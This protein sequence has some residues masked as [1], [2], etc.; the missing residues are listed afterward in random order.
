MV[1][2][3]LEIDKKDPNVSDFWIDSLFDRFDEDKSG[4]IDDDEWEHLL[5]A[6]PTHSMD[7]AA[8]IQAELA[9]IQAQLA[10]AELTALE[11]RMNRVRLAP[12]VTDGLEVARQASPLVPKSASKPKPPEKKPAAT[13]R[14]STPLLGWDQ[15]NPESVQDDAAQVQLEKWALEKQLAEIEAAEA[16]EELNELRLSSTIVAEDPLEEAARIVPTAT[17]HVAAA[18]PE[19]AVETRRLPPA[20]DASGSVMLAQRPMATQLGSIPAPNDTTDFQT[21]PVSPAPPKDVADEPAVYRAFLQLAA[22]EHTDFGAADWKF[23]LA[24]ESATTIGREAKSSSRNDSDCT[25][26]GTADNKR[27]SRQH[28]KVQ[29]DEASGD[30]AVSGIGKNTIKVNGE[31]TSDQPVVIHDGDS[32]S[33]GSIELSVK[34]ESSGD[35][36]DGSV[37][38]E[39]KC[40]NRQQVRVMVRIQL[41]L[42]HGAPPK[43]SDTWID[44][45]FD[46][47]DLDKSDTI[48][49]AEWDNMVA[50]L[51]THEPTTQLQSELAAIERQLSIPDDAR[52]AGD[53]VEAQLIKTDPGLAKAVGGSEVLEHAI[54][55]A[56]TTALNK[57]KKDLDI[58]SELEAKKAALAKARASIAAFDNAAP[59][60]ET[61]AASDPAPEQNEVPEDWVELDDSELQRARS[62]EAAEEISA[63]GSQTP[64]QPQETTVAIDFVLPGSLGLN[65]TP[66]G[67]GNGVMV[68][69]VQPAGQAA[70]HKEL[71]P[72]L[73]VTEVGGV[74][75]HGKSYDG[76]IESI[77]SHSARPLRIAFSEQPPSAPA[78]QQLPME[79]RLQAQQQLPQELDPDAAIV[80]EQDRLESDIAALEAQ[81]AQVAAAPV[82]IEA[83]TDV[84]AR[85]DVGLSAL[86]LVLQRH[87]SVVAEGEALARHPS[88]ADKIEHAALGEPAA[89]STDVDVEAE[90]ARV[91][92][93]P[94]QDAVAQ[95]IA[96]AE[97]LMADLTPVPHQEQPNPERTLDSRTPEPEPEPEPEQTM[98]VARTTSSLVE[99]RD[100]AVHSSQAKV[101]QPAP[102]PAPAPE[103]EPEPELTEVASATEP[104]PAAVV[105]PE[106]GL[107]QAVGEAPA[108]AD[109]EVDAVAEA[110]APAPVAEVEQTSDEV[111]AAG[112]PG[113]T[114]AEAADAAE[115][116][117]APQPS[118]PDL[119][120]EPAATTG[121]SVAVLGAPKAV[122]YV[123]TFLG[124]PRGPALGMKFAKHGERVRIRTIAPGK[125][126]ASMKQLK[127]GL[128]LAMVG[129][130]VRK[131]ISF[132]PFCT[133]QD[134]FTTTGSGQT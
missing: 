25:I 108:P 70:T 47:F 51:P 3:Q 15:L 110:E 75:M 131:R 55:A 4:T 63:S 111:A 132:V 11:Q 97:K 50:A 88:L 13:T 43:V 85:T 99:Q 81:I 48:D 124:P 79:P 126:A 125:Q 2:L 122:E 44:T 130:Q 91:K 106:P 121:R 17:K 59:P 62:S 7:T 127:V 116:A 65:L 82:A 113:T 94:D 66:F 118:A 6:L 31:A 9:L 10:T 133:K 115:L 1:R 27:I 21:R 92:L 103:P 102:A 96:D 74:S 33:I 69:A 112:A 19:L 64:Q 8:S 5:A 80:A 83:S 46:R 22:G 12:V 16:E 119:H 93:K 86:D 114:A 87:P 24:K 49:D 78:V 18:P 98:E 40:L 28:A 36:T 56:R 109:A 29:F 90:A 76:V 68:L 37:S 128:L 134:N 35:S 45:L 71:H 105:E 117:P 72:G 58:A 26:P 30:F 84:A 52:L 53:I 39:V 77:G 57:R 104:V 38:P 101:I 42:L 32:L 54:L 60:V 14:S 41:E 120:L 61:T 67:D 100:T 129:E 95:A 34:F 23:E 20:L 123:A 89:V 73:V 107:E